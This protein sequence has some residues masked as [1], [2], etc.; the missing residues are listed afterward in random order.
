MTPITDMHLHGREALAGGRPPFVLDESDQLK[1]AR[2]EAPAGLAV[3][4]R[5]G[6]EIIARHHDAPGA[7]A[8]A[9]Y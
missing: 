8:T 2:W 4:A 9:Q 7:T 3:T 6:R 1:R 5:E